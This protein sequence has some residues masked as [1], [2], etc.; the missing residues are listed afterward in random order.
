MISVWAQVIASSRSPPP[1]P[2]IPL[3]DAPP[4]EWEDKSSE[5]E[6]KGFLQGKK[7]EVAVA[8]AAGG[9]VDAVHNYL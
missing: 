2:L 8:V 7:R 9:R 3:Q 4:V 1:L 5:S 6:A